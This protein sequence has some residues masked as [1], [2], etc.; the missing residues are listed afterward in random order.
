[1]VAVPRIEL[2]KSPCKSNI[3]PLNHT[4]IICEI[5]GY[6]FNHTDLPRYYWNYNIIIIIIPLGKPM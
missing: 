3:I 4:A 5:K 2:G 6:N 1:M